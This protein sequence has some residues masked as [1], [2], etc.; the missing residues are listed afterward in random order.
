MAERL[1]VVEG[2]A[3]PSFW[4][5]CSSHCLISSRFAAELVSNGTKCNR[6]VF[7]P[8]RQGVL[9]T[10][11]IRSRLS[12]TVFISHEG[13][14][15]QATT[16]FYVWESGR[17]VTLSKTFM[18]E[19]QLADLRGLYSDDEAV[20]ARATV[21]PSWSQNQTILPHQQSTLNNI[22]AHLQGELPEEGVAMGGAR[23][24]DG[25]QGQ[26]ASSTENASREKVAHRGTT[27]SRHDAWTREKAEK[28][29][30]ELKEQMATKIP[31]LH[32]A[33]SEVAEEF[34]EAFG[35]DITM[36]CDFKKFKV[37]LKS[38]AQFICMLP[39]RLSE[40]MMREVQKQIDA[41]LHQG[42]IKKSSSPFAFSLVIVKRNGKIRVCC[43]FRILNDMTEPY[44]YAMPDLHDVLDRLAGKEFY[45][46]VDV[47]SFFNQIEVEEDSSQYMAFVVPGGAKYEFTR[48]PFGC[49]NAPA[50]A[51]QQLREELQ[52]DESTR[53]LINFID[54][55]TYGSNDME[56][57]VRKFRALLQFC[58]NHK[59]K[60]KR[61][62]CVLGAPAVKALGFVLNA[63]G[64]WIDP[65]RVLS[66]LKLPAAKGIKELRHL[67][68]SFNFV[69]SWLSGSADLCAPLFDLLKKDAKFQWTAE[70][71][72]S[73]ELLK[74]AVATAP[75]LGQID[76]RKPVYVRCDASDIGAACVLYQMVFNI[77][78][79]QEE[80]Q[81]I[82]YTA[83]RFS[84][85]ERR[86][87]LSERESSSIMLAWQ[88][89]AGMLAGLKVVVE[90]DHKNHL[91]MYSSKSMKVQR[92]R[93]W[94]QQYD[95]EVRHLPGKLNEP[96]DSLS[97]L[98][99]SLHL[100]NLFIDAPT[101]EQA[102]LER[103]QGIIAPST[104]LVG[105][106]GPAVGCDEGDSGDENEGDSGLDEALFNAC[107]LLGEDQ[108]MDIAQFTHMGAN[109]TETTGSAGQPEEC[110]WEEMGMESDEARLN[111]NEG[112]DK[113]ES[114]E[115][116]YGKGFKLLNKEGWIPGEW[117]GYSTPACNPP[118]NALITGGR[119]P[120]DYRGVGGYDHRPAPIELE[121]ANPLAVLLQQKFKRVHNCQAGHVGKVRSYARMRK[122]SGFPWGA[123]TAKIY[124]TVKRECEGCLLCNKIWST[125]GSIE[126]AG[127]AIIR[128]RPWTEVAM[129]LIVLD[130]ADEDGNKNILVIVDSF[131]RA[132]ELYPV[133]TGDAET[134]AACLFDVYNRYGRPRRVRCDGAKAFVKSV[135][136]RLNRLVGV[137]V[138]PILPYS[139][140]QNGQVERYNQEVMRHLRTIIL[141][142]DGRHVLRAKRWG[143]HTSAVRRLLN[144]TVNS[145]TGCT[146]NELLY[147]GFGDTET[148][149]FM[150]DVARE[151]GEPEA[152]WKFAK[153]LEDLQFEILRRSE[154]HQHRVLESAARRADAEGRRGI[155]EGSYVLCRRGGLGK[156]P[157][158]KLQSRFSG[159]YLVI[160]RSTNQECDSIVTCLH[161]GSK[162]VTNLHMAEV[163]GIDLSHLKQ[164]E[165]EAEA[166]KDEW[167][168]RVVGI[169]GFRP[170][171]PRRTG[172]S[173]RPKETYEFLV[174]YDLPESIESEEENPAWQPYSHVRHTSALKEFCKKPEIVR[175]LGGTFYVSE[176][177]E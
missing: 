72:R 31:A 78:T 80:P 108:L 41:W 163:V 107:G 24:R 106:S 47:S 37:R 175:D 64:K 56:D 11:V 135:V 97:R 127:G 176:G 75:C 48:V 177:E 82:A 83:R 60:L 35:E 88:K 130:E 65:D 166:I 49:K 124:D 2:R 86:W 91:Y 165:M 54:D 122:L 32:S 119:E 26:T 146:P 71:D 53:D 147:G 52:E 66:L 9:W 145:D 111:V 62:K 13:R 51:Q 42:V 148:S 3:V 138:H 174:K 168:Y 45:W 89:F 160:N 18:Q 149:L 172:R 68:G 33:L 36:P 157:K 143:L 79:K 103:Q 170:A 155:V 7:I 55:I 92:W 46:S 152:G 17:D 169:E 132:V 69:R 22:A 116:T 38:G 98:F 25:F 140:Y 102:N 96:V 128:Q 162:Q 100:N 16:E 8:M 120:G 15:I 93:M 137:A 10:G 99:E 134:A 85:A 141:G 58:V 110:I 77:R 30:E 171:G 131:T 6:D 153:E 142:E 164:H 94:L 129:D 173:L 67:L 109:E 90:T 154:E 40:P 84:P 29:R 14:H 150:E 101:T 114:P 76:A 19:H 23:A 28:L 39:R 50:W 87:C 136:K 81:A 161:M 117:L 57:S 44:P 104:V 112:A 20:K 5:S 73:L 151:Q 118:F 70:H 113:E 43:D 156:R 121:E 133:A 12:A 126:A 34:P 115:V 125:R 21:T 4:D 59:L 139:P 158:G 105:A 27:H 61:S 1:I 167:T 74:E 123:T 144:N 95:Y 63:Q 159:P